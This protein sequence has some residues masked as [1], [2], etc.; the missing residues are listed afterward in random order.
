M[1]EPITVTITSTVDPEWIKFCTWET[2]LFSRNY[3]G[4]WLRGIECDKERGWLVWEDDERHA[5]GKEP[6]LRAARKA[7]KEGAPLPKGYYRLDK[8][9]AVKAW[10]IGVLG[11]GEKWHDEGD[12]P[13]YDCVIQKALLGEERYG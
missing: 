4:Y 5:M 10:S 13:R 1:S 11:W 7:W 9:A 6:N 12:A 2:D 3:C 8:A